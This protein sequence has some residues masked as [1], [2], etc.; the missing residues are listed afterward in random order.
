MLRAKLDLD[1]KDENKIAMRNLE[2]RKN[3]Q[4]HLQ[5]I[6]QSISSRG[7]FIKV[8]CIDLRNLNMHSVSQKFRDIQRP[9]M[10]LCSRNLEMLS[11]LRDCSHSDSVQDERKCS[12]NESFLK[13]S[14]RNEIAP[15]FFEIISNLDDIAQGVIYHPSSL[16]N[17][18]TTHLSPLF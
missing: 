16:I 7:F 11:I 13:I 2:A 17:K 3:L 4:D 15:V 14:S 5:S 8:K 12:G 1:L 6:T 10:T 9:F 18:I